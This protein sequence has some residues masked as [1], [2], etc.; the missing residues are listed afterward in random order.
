MQE[1]M[2]ASAPTRVLW[3]E[4]EVPVGRWTAGSPLLWQPLFLQQGA[5]LLHAKH[6]LK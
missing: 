5:K 3:Q 6:N 2:P 4:G 1:Q